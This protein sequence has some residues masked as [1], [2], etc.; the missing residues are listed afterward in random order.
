MCVKLVA[1]VNFSG[2]CVG[3]AVVV[4]VVLVVHEFV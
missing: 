4:H 2:E 3:A 1:V